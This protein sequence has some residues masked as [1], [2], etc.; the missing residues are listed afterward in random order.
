[1]IGSHFSLLPHVIHFVCLNLDDG[2]SL[3]PLLS[4]T[5][6]T[7]DS[8]ETVGRGVS[9]SGRELEESHIDLLVVGSLFVF[10]SSLTILPPV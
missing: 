1:M 9:G 8:P 4:N 5:G 3:L 2:I 7:N 6:L 10:Y